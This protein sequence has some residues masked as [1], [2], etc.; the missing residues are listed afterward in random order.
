[1]M[2]AMLEQMKQMQ[3]RLEEVEHNAKSKAGIANGM[4]LNNF[5][6]QQAANNCG[7]CNT[8]C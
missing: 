4:G 6:L 7:C 8:C 1:M 2:S 3:Q 5:P